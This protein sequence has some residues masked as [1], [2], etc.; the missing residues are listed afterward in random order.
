MSDHY[1]VWFNWAGVQS[2]IYEPPEDLTK[3]H[4]A[5]Q[6]FP[7]LHWNPNGIDFVVTLPNE[8]DNL[9]ADTQVIHAGV[10][11]DI[12]IEQFLSAERA[13]TDIEMMKERRVAACLALGNALS[14]LTTEPFRCKPSII[15]IA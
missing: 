5:D 4:I 14:K 13:T 1:R 12:L 3:V 9:S 10:N 6:W 8:P 2:T 15:F 7:C 11:V